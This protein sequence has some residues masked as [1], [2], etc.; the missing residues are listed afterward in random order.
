MCHT[1]VSG[2]WGQRTGSWEE[3]RSWWE[4]F[5]SLRSDYIATGVEVFP[6]FSHDTIVWCVPADLDWKSGKAFQRKWHLNWEMKEGPAQL[7]IVVA[8]SACVNALKQYRQWDVWGNERGGAYGDRRQSYQQEPGSLGPRDGGGVTFAGCRED[9]WEATAEL[10][11]EMTIAW[12]KVA[13][14]RWWEVARIRRLRT[15]RIWRWVNM[16]MSEGV[17]CHGVA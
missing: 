13:R 5:R 10:R 2:L 11:W 1:L 6:Y 7:G 14:Q 16:Q 3:L 4:A 17:G 12:T 9:I 8:E 15:S